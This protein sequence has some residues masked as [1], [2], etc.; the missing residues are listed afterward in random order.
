MP[1]RSHD[2]RPS[3][4]LTLLASLPL[5]ALL[6]ALVLG[7]A[8]G[9][10]TVASADA[11]DI[12]VTGSLTGEVF[13]DTSACSAASGAIGD[14]LPGVDPW[15][16]AQDASGQACTLSF[17]S[18]DHFPGTNLILVDD[19]A[20]SGVAGPA[21]RCSVGGCAG[22]SIADYSGPGE[23]AVNASA[24]GTQLLG[25]GGIATQAWSAAPAVHAVQDTSDVPC[26]TAT[27]GTGSCSFTWGMT[28]AAGDM[29][30]AY[31]ASIQS[32]VVAR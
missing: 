27:T 9:R 1:T 4:R 24:F 29:P 28:A 31:R 26:S 16:T 21:L 30:G 11:A 3:L 22:R 6:A 14:V 7:M 20:T 25:S 15:K 13:L 10:G 18:L 23:P 17:G 19:P 2:I 12:E 5:V 32:L 8:T